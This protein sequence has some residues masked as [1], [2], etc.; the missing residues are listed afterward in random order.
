MFG[1]GIHPSFYT[2]F[3]HPHETLSS[4]SHSLRTH[5]GLNVD[6]VPKQEIK[7][8]SRSYLDRD[9]GV[10]PSFCVSHVDL[11]HAL[12]SV[13]SLV[14]RQHDVT[15]H[16]DIHYSRGRQRILDSAGHMTS[17]NEGY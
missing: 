1:E 13:D 16:T 8:M 4:P 10:C 5:V 12:P 9:K 6:R 7:L 3:S 14:T 2:V 15:L 11:G 17:I